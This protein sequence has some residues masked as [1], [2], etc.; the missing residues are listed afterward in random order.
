MTDRRNIADRALDLA[1]EVA[2]YAAFDL[3]TRR[4]IAHALSLVPQLRPIINPNI[5]LAGNPPLPFAVG[6]IEAAARTAAYAHIAPLRACTGKGAAGQRER[7]LAFGLLLEPAR[8]DLRW[9]R[10]TSLAAFQFCYERLVGPAWRELL[11]LAWKES[12]LQRR[13]Q[14]APRQLPLDPRLRE[15]AMVPRSLEDDP[16]PWFYPSLADAEAAEGAPL[17]S[18]LY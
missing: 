10:L 3:P 1:G 4:F 18:L 2:L 6:E 14:A 5:G 8:V 11:P 15:D 7:R 13:K 12:V 17:L 16:A 9:K